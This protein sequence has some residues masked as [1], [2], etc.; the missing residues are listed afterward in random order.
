MLRFALWL[1]L[2][3]VIALPA[4]AQQTATL[5]G[6]VTDDTGAPLPGVNVFLAETQ[7]GTTTNAEGRYRLGSVPLGAHR[8]VASIVGFETAAANLVLREPGEARTVDF[9]LGEAEYEL[10]EVTVESTR[11]AQW[12]ERY[13]RFERRFIGETA[14]AAETEI[15]D[16]YVLDFDQR[17]GTLYAE[18][19]EPLVVENRALGY[20]VRYD[21][22]AFEARS[23]ANFYD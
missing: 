16:P 4:R 14:N 1:V 13:E 23:D 18:A 22:T 20:R 6:T 3:T 9:R 21:L 17:R 15:L 10:G 12:Q 11:D 8:L 19:R 5:A 7:R 2:A